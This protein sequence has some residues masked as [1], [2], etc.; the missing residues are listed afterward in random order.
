MVI[1][2]ELTF[3]TGELQP[4]E[5]RPST[6]RSRRAARPRC[7]SSATPAG[8]SSTR[9]GTSTARCRTCSA[10]LLDVSEANELLAA[11]GHG[12]LRLV[13][14]GEID[15]DAHTLPPDPGRGLE[16]RRGGS[17]HA[18]PRLRA[19]GVHRRG[20]LARGPGRGGAWSG[21]FFLVAN[22]EVGDGPLPGN[23]E[24]TEAAMSEGFYEAVITALAESR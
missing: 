6:P 9:P 18:R 19:R 20:R 24:R 1:D 17:A 2:G 5:G 8:S 12:D 15:P 4:R 11:D 21:R 13:D 23:V 16:G 14:N 7:C 3:L 22:A 10:A